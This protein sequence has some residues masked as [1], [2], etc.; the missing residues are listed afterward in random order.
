MSNDGAHPRTG[1][2]A[3]PKNYLSLTN[4]LHEYIIKH[5]LREP[6]IARRLREKTDAM[7][8]SAM[9]SPPEQSQ[10]VALV[11][12][13]IGAR[14]CLEIGT[15]TGYTTLWLAHAIP[16]D[17]SIVC[18]D[19]DSKWPGVGRPFWEE[20]G[21]A[22]RI[23]LRIGPALRT[24]EELERTGYA[25]LFDLVFI[26]A[27]KENYPAYYEHGLRLVRPGGVVLVDN[28][29]WG[30]SVINPENQGRDAQAVRELNERIFYDSA[31][32]ISML[33]IGDGLTLVLRRP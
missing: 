6:D 27:D 13:M 24:L 14:R 29:L 7:R 22:D 31:V 15:F 5:S 16:P 2:K 30:G 33:P 10:L 18:C 19:I 3:L 21:V 9:A 32:A 23:D 20:A 26:D 11:A 4:P 8:M 12:Q 25:N 1:G 28:V 17:G